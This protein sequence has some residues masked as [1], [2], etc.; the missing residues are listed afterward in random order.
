MSQPPQI[1]VSPDHL[2]SCDPFPKTV[3]YLALSHCWGGDVALKTTK[4][5][6]LERQRRISFADI[7]GTF[8]D[9]VTVTRDVGLNYL[10][11]NAM[12]AV[13]DEDY[14]NLDKQ[15]LHEARNSFARIVGCN[16]D[17]SAVYVYHNIIHADPFEIVKGKVIQPLQ[18]RALTTQEQALPTRMV[19]FT[20][21]E[22][23]W[24]CEQA[25]QFE[26]ETVY[27]G[28]TGEGKGFFTNAQKALWLY[29]NAEDPHIQNASWKTV[30]NL[31]WRRNITNKM[32]FLPALAGIASKASCGLMWSVSFLS[33]RSQRVI[34]YRA[35]SRSRV[36]LE[37]T[38]GKPFPDIIV[39]RFYGE[40]THLE[41][42]ADVEN[43]FCVPDGMNIFGAVSSGEIK[44]T[45]R[46]FQ[47][48]LTF[49]YFRALELGQPK[50]VILKLYHR[51]PIITS[52]FTFTPT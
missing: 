16:G 51:Q 36:S 5:N 25:Y 15:N 11:I 3:P 40:D 21:H 30:L 42:W 38:S 20:Q 4:E 31:Y 7:P 32:D 14:K 41:T 52:R 26:C 44:I 18:K 39:T 49:F 8:Q 17:V 6:Y 13:D 47:T 43:A 24:H 22:L 34:P 50:L 9:A 48:K 33:P 28:I 37:A 2:L 46:I 23:F 35:P 19:H 1:H 12:C 10:W 45:G 29:I 27:R